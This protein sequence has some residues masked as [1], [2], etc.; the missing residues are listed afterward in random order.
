MEYDRIGW[1]VQEWCD[2][3]DSA[4]FDMEYVYGGDD[5]GASYMPDR[6]LWKI[7]TP[8]A[9]KVSL[10]LYTTG[11][12]QEAGA[13]RLRQ[14]PMISR[15]MRSLEYFSGRRLEGNLL[16]VFDHLGG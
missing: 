8:V 16:Y 14:V 5:L 11:S 4:Q 13:A 1:S 7:W 3:F 12:D 15:S 2:W 6:T 10:N 9:Q